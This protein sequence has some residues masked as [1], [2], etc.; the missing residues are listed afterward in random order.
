MLTPFF[1]LKFFQ[2]IVLF[3]S[4]EEAT[5][6]GCDQILSANLAWF[7]SFFF[8]PL[9]DAGGVLWKREQG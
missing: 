9:G 2:K 7:T 1:N 4:F 5:E 8:T 6:D 3:F